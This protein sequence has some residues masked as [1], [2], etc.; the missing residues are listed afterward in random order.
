MQLGVLKELLLLLHLDGEVVSSIRK[1]REEPP[2]LL[3]LLP[4]WCWG[5]YC[6]WEGRK[7][8][9]LLLPCWC[10]G[11]YCIWEGRKM[12]LL[13]LPCWC[14]GTYSI[15]EGR[16]CCCC[17]LTSGGAFP[18]VGW[19][20]KKWASCFCCYLLV[21]LLCWRWVFLIHVGRKKRGCNCYLTAVVMFFQ[22][23]DEGRDLPVLLLLL[24]CKWWRWSYFV[25]LFCCF[26][27]PL[28]LC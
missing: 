19:G 5:T 21:F 10:W 13:L 23:Q 24:P 25:M 12:L 6:I 22:L 3:L 16:D 18:S 2:V 11:T 8:L 7:M 28:M 9:L 27:Q 15:W 26:L 14:W 4:C 17:C 1:D 20:R